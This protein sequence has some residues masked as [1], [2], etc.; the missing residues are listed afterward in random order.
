MILV[1]H[2]LQLMLKYIVLITLNYVFVNIRKVVSTLG[3][4]CMLWK[5]E[6]K[7]QAG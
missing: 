4:I 2:V 3:N 6:S 5:E 7:E 1:M